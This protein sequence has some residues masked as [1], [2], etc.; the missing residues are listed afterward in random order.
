MR[1]GS[2]PRQHL[3]GQRPHITGQCPAPPPAIHRSQ[4]EG[5]KKKP[6]RGQSPGVR[7][8]PRTRQSA[9]GWECLPPGTGRKFRPGGGGGGLSRT[10][11][12]G[13]WGEEVLGAIFYGAKHCAALVSKYVAQ[14]P[15]GGT[16]DFAVGLSQ[17]RRRPTHHVGVASPS[18]SRR[19]RRW[20]NGGGLWRERRLAVC[21]GDA[22]APVIPLAGKMGPWDV[23]A[24]VRRPPPAPWPHPHRIGLG[25]GWSRS[26]HPK[27][28]PAHLLSGRS[29]RGADRRPSVPHMG[30]PALIYAGNGFKWGIDRRD[31]QKARVETLL[32]RHKLDLD[33]LPHLHPVYIYVF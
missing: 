15:A 7:F 10:P 31:R 11:L 3:N 14:P 5:H 28:L 12:G 19:T 20:E 2:I 26:V 25:N 4:Q 17:T 24:T 6:N 30:P 8:P 16:D 29:V 22:P 23:P 33:S 27:F 13:N 21:D 32:L 9:A 18:G 1:G